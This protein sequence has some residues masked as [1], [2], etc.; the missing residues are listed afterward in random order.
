MN[1]RPLIVLSLIAAFLA[2]VGG[3]ALSGDH[4]RTSDTRGIVAAVRPVTMVGSWNQTSG[5]SGVTMTATVT[6]EGTISISMNG[7]AYWAGSF[8]TTSASSITST[9]D[10]EPQMSQDSTKNFTYNNGD[11]SFPFSILGQTATI[12]LQR[13]S[14]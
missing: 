1:K 11:L 7:E 5:M 10:G 2:I 13:S 9:A 4:A 6:P 14:K 12:H 3:F 8:K